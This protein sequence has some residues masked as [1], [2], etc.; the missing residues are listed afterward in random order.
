MA[1]G[2]SHRV[3]GAENSWNTT[4]VS[5]ILA[6]YPGIL[7]Q[8]PRYWGGIRDTVAVSWA[9]LSRTAIALVV[10]RQGREETREHN[11]DA[12]DLRLP[13]R[14]GP[15]AAPCPTAL[16]RVSYVPCLAHVYCAVVS[17]SVR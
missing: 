7:A 10:E 1:G 11:I 17:S 5:G 13:R 6:E 12:D 9:V 15:L 16:R 8:Y 3:C 14:H 4:L 2:E